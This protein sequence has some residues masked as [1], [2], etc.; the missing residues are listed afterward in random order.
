MAN[1]SNLT[2]AQ[3]RAARA[4]LNWSARR[5]SDESGVSPSTIHRAES[6]RAYPSTH[7]QRLAAIKRALERSGVDFL[8]SSGVRLRAVEGDED[9]CTGGEVANDVGRERLPW[10]A[11]S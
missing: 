3:I 11:N 9:N 4:L 8:D 10:L 2:S 1:K 7:E 5:L 6:A